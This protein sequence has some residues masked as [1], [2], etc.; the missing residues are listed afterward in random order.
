MIL[1]NVLPFGFEILHRRCSLLNFG[2][3][4]YFGKR[5]M[6]LHVD[7]F[8]I[9]KDSQVSKKVFSTAIYRYD[10]AMKAVVGNC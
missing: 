7:A 4:E 9:K 8:F 10:Q 6:S 3:R 1:M 5:E 2:I